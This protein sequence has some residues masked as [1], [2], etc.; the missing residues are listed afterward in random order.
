MSN[1][2]HRLI[3]QIL[4]ESAVLWPDKVALVH[5]ETRATYAEINAQANSLAH[6]LRGIGVVEGDRVV[7]LSENSLRYVVGYFGA[8]KSGAVVAPLSSDLKPDS[9]RP[10]LAELAP[11]IILASSRFE[12]LVR[13][14][15]PGRFNIRTVVLDSPALS[16]SSVSCDVHEWDD[17]VKGGN[18]ANPG[19]PLAPGSLANIIY[20][21]GS[22]GTPK[23]VML[24]H[25]NIVSNT[26]SIC[27]S[28]DL[29]EADIQM[30]V[31]PF[32]YV[33]GQS[34]LN[35]H[36][37][38]GG[39]LVIENRFAYPAA[40][41]RRMVDE[42]VTGFSGVPSTFAYLLHRSPL[43][44]Y[45]DKLH[46][47]RYCSQAGGHMPRAVKEG[48]RRVLPAHTRIYIMYGCTEASARLS[49]L[50]PEAFEKKID[51]IGKAISDVTLVVLDSHGRE[52][53]P[54][55]AG[56][57]RGG[58]PQRHDGLLAR[59]RDDATGSGRERLSHRRSRVS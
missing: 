40:A 51:S 18:G 20:T 42:E 55:Q 27:R 39:T 8:L 46:S 48:L 43:A 36:F 59:S 2:T 25:R 28:L 38:V 30:V 1:T 7:L 15:D 57:A 26:R 13:E 5:G 58:R 6:R 31:L 50:E 34:L 53:P 32:F 16:W 52:L 12:Q 37:A 21:S 24:S 14:A 4:E 35:T 22:S 9:L 54:R 41:L 56:R 47:L 29:T 44:K 17:W 33:M 10:L 23:G 11:S 49:V 3:H 45:R 19:L